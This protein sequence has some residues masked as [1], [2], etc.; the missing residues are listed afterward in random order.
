[1]QVATIKRL[2]LILNGR[3]IKDLRLLA[4]LAKARLLD[5]PNVTL[6][7]GIPKQGSLIGNDIANIEYLINEICANTDKSEHDDIEAVNNPTTFTT[8]E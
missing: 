4:L 2:E 6:R 5:I 8:K 3:E 1:M 7:G